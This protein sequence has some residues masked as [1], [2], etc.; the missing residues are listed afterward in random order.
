MSIKKKEV[1]AI[2]TAINKLLEAKPTSKKLTYSLVRNIGLLAPELKA[3]QTAY[4]TDSEKY[5]EYAQKMQVIYQEYGKY[6]EKTNQLIT[7]NAGFVL[8]DVEKKD[9]VQEKVTALDTEYKDA[10]EERAE[11]I[12]AYQEILEEEITVEL[13][14]LNFEELPEDTTPDIFYVLDS[15]ITEPK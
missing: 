12:K 6:D 5:T 1:L 3:I 7:N 2:N 4:D 13:R 11:E 8:K 14:E 15:I 9:E 10:L